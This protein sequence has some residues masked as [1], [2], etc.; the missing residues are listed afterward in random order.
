[1]SIEVDAE[2][3]DIWTPVAVQIGVPVESVPLES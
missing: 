1:V 3:I 2:D